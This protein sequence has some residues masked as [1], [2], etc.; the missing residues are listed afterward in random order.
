[1]VGVLLVAGG[2]MVRSGPAARADG[3]S[4]VFAIGDSLTIGMSPYL[5]ARAAASGWAGIRI[6]AFK[7]RGIRTKVGADPTT[8]LGAVTSMRQRFGDTDSWIVAL[9]TNDAGFSSGAGTQLIREMLDAIGPGHRVLWVNVHLPR[10]P[11]VQQAWNTALNQVA[12][13]RPDQLFVLDWASIA[14]RQTGI[15]AFDGVHLT[16]GGYALMAAA[17]A[18]ASEALQVGAEKVASPAVGPLEPPSGVWRSGGFVP[19][20]PVRLLDTRATVAVSAGSI[21]PVDLSGRVPVGTVAAALNVTATQAIDEGYL[22]VFPCDRPRP[23]TSVVN[24]MPGLDASSLV[25]AAVSVSGTVCVFASSTMHVLVD[26]TGAF[27]EGSGSGLELAAPVR[28]V[29]TR[30]SQRLAAGSVLA[31]DVPGGWNAALLNLT[32]VSPSG[33]GF[34]TAYPCDVPRPATSNLNIA[35][36]RPA[37]ANAAIV[38]LSRAGQLC[39]YTSVAVDV[40]VDLFGRFSAGAALHLMPVVPQRLL[41]TR[42]GVGAWR[43]RMASGGTIDVTPANITGSVIGTL[44]VIDPRGDGYVTAWGDGARPGTSNVNVQ[45]NEVIANFVVG[46]PGHDGRLELFAGDGAGEYLAFDITGVFA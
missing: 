26:L 43:G 18:T 19:T 46:A 24:V 27:V 2:P 11:G 37:K 13:E 25:V 14:A 45:Q 1:M 5:P 12:A 39:V 10:T 6:D 33:A 28:S 42:A 8:G 31:V 20:A 30:T 35:A 23:D 44:T 29:D 3:G 32:A 17:V 7:S 34:L 40:V 9:G 16:A 22:T 41:D 21:V 36:G 38:G 15:M 4:L